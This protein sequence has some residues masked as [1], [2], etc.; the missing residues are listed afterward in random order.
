[1]RARIAVSKR[2]GAAQLERQVVRRECETA[3]KMMICS[4]H[5]AAIKPLACPRSAV[6][7]HPSRPTICPR[8]GGRSSASRASN[9][10]AKSASFEIELRHTE[11]EFCK[12]DL[13]AESTRSCRHGSSLEKYHYYESVGNKRESSIDARNERVPKS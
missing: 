3:K 4:T 13:T 10:S 12:S 11:L 9:R 6:A 7:I 2:R 1:V 8:P 5:K